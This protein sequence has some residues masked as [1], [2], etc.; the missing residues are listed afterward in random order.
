VELLICGEFSYDSKICKGCQEAVKRLGWFSQPDFVINYIPCPRASIRKKFLQTQSIQLFLI[1][2]S[3][4]P[5]S[6]K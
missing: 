6:A 2:R 3:E 1:N 5:K 4:M